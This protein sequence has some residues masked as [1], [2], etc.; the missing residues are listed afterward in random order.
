MARQTNIHNTRFLFLVELILGSCSA[1]HQT[2]TDAHTHTRGHT[3]A[4]RARL[5]PRE[6]LLSFCLFSFFP[7][8][9]SECL[10]PAAHREIRRSVCLL[11]PAVLFARRR[12]FHGDGECST[13]CSALYL[14]ER[15]LTCMDVLHAS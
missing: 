2:Q 8:L 4:Q 9:P 15:L 11:R 14:I 10:T 7:S 12:L 3:H 13:F 6:S 5:T 1:W